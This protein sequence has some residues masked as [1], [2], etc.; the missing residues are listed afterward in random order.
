[1]K[2]LALLVI[3]AG[4][5][6]LITGCIGYVV[7]VPQ[8]GY[9]NGYYQAPAVVYAPRPAY[10]TPIYP[11]NG[12]I[13]FRSGVGGHYGGGHYYGGASRGGGHRRR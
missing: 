3:T 2:K 13:Y 11:Y 6:F 8:G 10:V 7:P 9:T 4:V 12:G 1:M 5:F